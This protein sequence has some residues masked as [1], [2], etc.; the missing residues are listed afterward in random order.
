MLSNQPGENCKEGRDWTKVVGIGSGIAAAAVVGG[1][2]SSQV[3][4][5]GGAAAGISPGQCADLSNP[6]TSLQPGQGADIPRPGP[7][8]L[9]PVELGPVELGLVEFAS[10][11]HSLRHRRG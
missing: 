6:P 9:S 11:R 2:A 10:C 3:L 7:V 1:L 5:T 4:F 8:E